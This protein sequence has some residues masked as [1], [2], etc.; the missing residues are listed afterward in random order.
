MHF[1]EVAW[2]PK[3][4]SLELRILNRDHQVVIGLCWCQPHCL[5]PRSSLSS[6]STSQV[7]GASTLG[8]CSTKLASAKSLEQTLWLFLV[9]RICFEPLSC[10]RG[11]HNNVFCLKPCTVVLLYNIN[12]FCIKRALL[13]EHLINHPTMNILKRVQCSEESLFSQRFFGS[14]TKCFIAFPIL[15]DNTLFLLKYLLQLNVEWTQWMCL[16]TNLSALSGP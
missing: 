10:P 9:Y 7:S 4:F 3:C 13:F 2:P 11:T 8:A 5:T 6:P 1:K 14:Q 12:Y 15:S 16:P